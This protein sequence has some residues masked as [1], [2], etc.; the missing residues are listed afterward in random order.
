MKNI[1]LFLKDIIKK[2]GS[3]IIKSEIKDL[4]NFLQINASIQSAKFIEKNMLKI[5]SFHNKFELLKYAIDVSKSSSIK[6][7]GDFLEFGVYKGTTINY[8]SKNIGKN[9]V[10][11]FDSFEGLPEDWRTG[12]SKGVFKVDKLPKVNSNVKLVKGYFNNS[13]NKFKKRFPNSI[14]RFIHIDC[15]LYSSTK[16]IF[17]N[18][19]NKIVSGTV[20]VFDEF[21]NYS[22][23]M[24]GE[25][26]AFKEFI[27]KNNIKFEYLGYVKNDEQVAVKII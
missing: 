3:I 2:F 13:I 20:I 24:E 25:Y 19:E 12:F 5:P 7:K 8:I 4:D 23:W 26:K 10:Y 6:G 14:C 9:I 11:G 15:D 18:L 16:C 21:F 1:K 22:G 17:D 27:I